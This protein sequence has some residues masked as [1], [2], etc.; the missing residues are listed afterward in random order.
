MHTYSPTTC[1]FKP[2]F[3]QLSKLQQGRY[4]NSTPS[5][6]YDGQTDQSQPSTS[7]NFNSFL[8]FNQPN[9]PTS[10]N[11]PTLSHHISSWRSHP[12]H[13][14]LR[15]YLQ[16][17]CWDRRYCLHVLLSIVHRCTNIHIHNIIILAFIQTTKRI[18]SPIFGLQ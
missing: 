10:F 3:K 17:W 8:S 12:D 1:R 18:Q 16:F 5:E 13:I 6:H 9:S 14:L 11:N 4:F 7:H 15:C 2:H